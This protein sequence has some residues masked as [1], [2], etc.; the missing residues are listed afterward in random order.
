LAIVRIGFGCVFVRHRD[1]KR[2]FSKVQKKR[3]FVFASIVF[4]VGAMM[5]T[6]WFFTRG[7]QHAL[8]YANFYF[9]KDAY[10]RQV[11]MVKRTEGP[12]FIVFRWKD[13][14]EQFLIFDE[15]DELDK[16]NGGKS[17]DWWLRA[18]EQQYRLAVCDW[19]STN[20]AKHFYRV[21]FSCEYPYD[22]STIPPL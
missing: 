22:G 17:R 13:F 1:G 6:P 10:L 4:S 20:V 19:S 15:S 21:I 8:N 7:I 18:K 12:R 3:W 14:N 16:G 2:G 5:A 9:V 11:A